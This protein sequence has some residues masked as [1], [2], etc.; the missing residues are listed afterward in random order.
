[1]D[2]SRNKK[3][4]GF[5]FKNEIR[6]SIERKKGMLTE[7]AMKLDP[8]DPTKVLVGAEQKAYEYDPTSGIIDRGQSDRAES[9]ARELKDLRNSLDGLVEKGA[10]FTK[11]AKSGRDPQRGR[12]AGTGYKIKRYLRKLDDFVQEF[13]DA[14]DKESYNKQGELKASFKQNFPS[15]GVPRHKLLLRTKHF[16]NGGNINQ[17]ELDNF[18]KKVRNTRVRIG[19]E[20]RAGG[21]LNLRTQKQKYAYAFKVT[22]EVKKQADVA[23]TKRVAA[24]RAAAEKEIVKGKAKGAVTAKDTSTGKGRFISAEFDKENQRFTVEITPVEESPLWTSKGVPKLSPNGRKQLKASAAQENSHLNILIKMLV[25]AF[26]GD[27]PEA[28]GLG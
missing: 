13:K 5:D 20:I 22:P 4:A 7:V 25:K 26:R 15:I 17:I 1:M 2:A 10:G 16:N 11:E 6:R 23:T 28:T 24:G 21:M 27:A 9:L 12:P 19:G 14:Y 3:M 8:N 18:S